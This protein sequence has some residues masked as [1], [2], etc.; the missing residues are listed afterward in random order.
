VNP[1]LLSQLRDIHAAPLAPW[2]PPAPG[3]WVLALLAAAALLWLLR[4]ALR[5]Y[6]ARRRRQHLARFLDSL[7]Q[8]VDPA[9]Q[10][11]AFLSAVNRVFKIV[12]LRAF[13]GERCAR[14]QGRD[15]VDFLTA[16]LAGGAT[17][18]ALVVLADAP[19]RPAPEFDA[20]GLVALARRWVMQ[21]G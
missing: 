19:Y 21:H 9:V 10:P 6:R 18:E 3:W 14:M 11:Q 1:D 13:P 8:Q 20:D 4:K 15:W 5:A 16:R 7:V 2:W 12:A 17:A